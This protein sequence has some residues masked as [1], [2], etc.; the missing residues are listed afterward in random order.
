MGVMEIKDT[1]SGKSS[2]H[3]LLPHLIKNVLACSILQEA[4]RKIVACEVNFQVVRT[5]LF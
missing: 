3:Q 4:I 5:A 2:H 1:C